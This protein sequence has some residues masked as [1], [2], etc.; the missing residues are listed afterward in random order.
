MPG[1]ITTAF[2]IFLR[3]TRNEA[4]FLARV[5]LR[6]AEVTEITDPPIFHFPLWLQ[7]FCWLQLLSFIP[8]AIKP[9][10]SHAW[11]TLW[12]TQFWLLQ[13][14]VMFIIMYFQCMLQNNQRGFFFFPFVD[15][16]V[17]CELI[18]PQTKLHSEI[19]RTDNFYLTRFEASHNHF[20][21]FARAE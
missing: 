11:G 15:F 21:R 14:S 12:F 1:K 8:A 17:V 20:E 10:N 19:R 6:R 7:F 18:L 4:V 5:D 2:N 13:Q 3:E 16:I 9:L